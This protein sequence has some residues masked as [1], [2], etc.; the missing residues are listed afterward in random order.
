MYYKDQANNVE[1]E[2]LRSF[3]CNSMNKLTNLM[4]NQSD[5]KNTILSYTFIR[6][7]NF[8]KNLK[9]LEKNDFFEKSPKTKKIIFFDFFQDFQNSSSIF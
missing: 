1:N 7:R 9:K 2:N 8:S 5:N 4:D 6:I 3:F